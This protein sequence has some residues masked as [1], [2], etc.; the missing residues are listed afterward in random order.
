[1]RGKLTAFVAGAV[2][3]IL[4]G[5]A[6][7]ADMPVKA[8]VAPV[9]TSWTGFYGGF[10][11]GAVISRKRFLDNFPVF[12]GEIDAEPQM[13]GWLAGLQ[14]GYNYQIDRNWL[15]GVEGE[16]SWSDG[17]K[18][19][20]CFT[21]G[22]QRC[23]ANLQWLATLTGRVGAIVGSSLFYVKGG[24]AWAHD[25]YTDLATCAGSQPTSRGGVNADCGVTYR[26]NQTHVGWVLGGG[27]EYRLAQ[28]WTLKAEYSFVDLGKTS[29]PFHG[30]N[31]G[32]FTEEIHQKVHL[33]K[34]GFNYLFFPGGAGAAA[35]AAPGA[36]LWGPDTAS[37]A[38]RFEVFHGFEVSR[39]SYGGYAG[40]LI[41]PWNDTDTSGARLYIL[42]AAG[43]YRYPI[44]GGRITGTY[45]E[46]DILPGYAWEGDTYSI[47]LLAG[48]NLINNTLSQPDPT[49]AVQGTQAGAKVRASAYANP[50]E[51]SMVFGDVEYSTAFS[52]FSANGKTGYA[53]FGKEV[54]F[55]PEVS[56]ARDVRSEQYRVGGHI[57]NLKLGA[58]SFDI[59]LGY[60]DNT[61]LGRGAY[62]RLEASRTF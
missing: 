18:D 8:S 54:Y 20:S 22:D 27:V 44:D 5:P 60:S 37:T 49:N 12:D 43:R 26:A 62:T 30:D 24:A 36:A 59:S 1:M 46:A 21:F 34:L 17:R 40:A 4:T 15:V 50:T 28:Y 31:G 47:N 9:A 48:L 23:S 11:A 6:G 38:G 2:V 10:H 61:I 52:T 39:R 45:A 13:T 51:A 55:G 32:F 19:F 53:L 16:F 35:S 25:S 57:S 14:A 7:A 58:V 56:F 3:A 33:A 29:V 41:A 42:G